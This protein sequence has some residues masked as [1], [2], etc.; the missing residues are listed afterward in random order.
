MK[1]H[2]LIISLDLA[3][4]ENIVNKAKLKKEGSPSEFSGIVSIELVGL[5]SG[6]VGE[7]DH[8]VSTLE[9]VGFGA[10]PEFIST[11]APD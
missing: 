11:N 3:T 7:E 8:V 2:K 10:K 6:L 9:R 1:D 4:L 5:P